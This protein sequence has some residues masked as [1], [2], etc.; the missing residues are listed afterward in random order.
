MVRES[1]S[2]LASAKRSLAYLINPRSSS[3]AT[4]TTSSSS[5]RPLRRRTRA[6]LYTL[7]YIAIFVFWRAVRYAKYVAIG[8]LGATAIGTFVGPLGW[9]VAPT[10]I[11]ASIV[12]GTVWGVGR[13]G[14]RRV[15][16]R[17]KHGREVELKSGGEGEEV[18]R[19]EPDLQAVPW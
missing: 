17:W 12:A 3:S 13:W 10:G 6:L 9:L 18:Y 16:R 19:K 8:A 11:G 7:R 14:V 1:D 15:E 5:S 4:T 2:A